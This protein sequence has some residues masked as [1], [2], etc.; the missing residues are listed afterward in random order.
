MHGAVSKIACFS[1]D[2][3]GIAVQFWP[4]LIVLLLCLG[5]IPGHYC[6][7]TGALQSLAHEEAE[8][9]GK[10]KDP[11]IGQGCTAQMK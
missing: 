2:A 3:N 4:Q 6:Q 8:H 7:G 5:A 10:D 1:T 11:I 9:V